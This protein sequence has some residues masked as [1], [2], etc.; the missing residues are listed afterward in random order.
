VTGACYSSI[1]LDRAA[2]GNELQS[3]YRNAVA[4]FYSS[5]I[6]FPSCSPR[7]LWLAN[8]LSTLS[9]TPHKSKSDRLLVSN[10]I[11]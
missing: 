9:S 11:I 2:V 10:A 8:L 6:D 3:D 1:S 4:T 5:Q 7:F